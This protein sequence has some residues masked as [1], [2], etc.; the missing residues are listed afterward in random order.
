MDQP[1]IGAGRPDDTLDQPVIGTGWPDDALDQNPSLCARS[2]MT[3]WSNL[4]SAPKWRNDT[5]DQP[6]MGAGWPDDTLDQPVI[7]AEVAG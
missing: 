4:S 5:L 1:V 2:R 7:G 3:G 6:V